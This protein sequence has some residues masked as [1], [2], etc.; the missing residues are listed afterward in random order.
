MKNV[1]YISFA[2]IMLFFAPAAL[3]A[4][5]ENACSRRSFLYAIVVNLLDWNFLI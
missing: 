5:I 3:N 4:Q 1:K 2:V